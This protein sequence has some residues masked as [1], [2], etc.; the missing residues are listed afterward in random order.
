RSDLLWNQRGGR[1]L[2]QERVV[3]A[4]VRCDGASSEETRFPRRNG[5]RRPAG[6]VPG[7]RVGG[8]RGSGRQRQAL[9]GGNLFGACPLLKERK[10]PVSVE[11][12]LWN[13][14]QPSVDPMQIQRV[15][16]MLSAYA[17]DGES[18]YADDE[19]RLLHLP[20]RVT[21]ESES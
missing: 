7:A 13:F 3:L 1:P 17:C 15:R 12:G 9:Y 6:T 16:K 14:Q 11:Y 18:E 19:I 10:C 20:F 21:P 8:S 5:H 2:F 4:A